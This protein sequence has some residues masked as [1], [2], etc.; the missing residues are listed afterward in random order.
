MNYRLVCRLLIPLLIATAPGC[1]RFWNRQPLDYQTISASPTTDTDKAVSKNDNALNCLERGQLDRAERL[2]QQALIADVTYGPAHN[3]LGQLYFN[4]KKYYLAAWEF[5]YAIKLMPDRPEPYNNLGLVYEK[6]GKLNEAVETF[7]I[8]FKLRPNNPEVIGNLARVRM[9]RGDPYTEIHP[10][11]AELKFLDTRPEW[12]VWA[13]E[14]IALSQD[15]DTI[16]AQPSI[17]HIPAPPGTPETF[18]TPES[19][20]L[21]DISPQHMPQPPRDSKTDILTLTP[22]NTPLR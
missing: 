22:L 20:Y 9:R 3:N 6:V 13:K 12:V 18:P 14:Q 16:C 2:F 7:E 5:E 8:A 17:E 4:Q 21:P 11:L 15:A 19:E 1:A 10:L